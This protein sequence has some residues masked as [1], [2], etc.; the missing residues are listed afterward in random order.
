MELLDVIGFQSG[1]H[2]FDFFFLIRSRKR[3][4]RIL[5]SILKPDFYSSYDEP[6]KADTH[7]ILSFIAADL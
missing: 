7:L 4:W 6:V 5:N 2:L 1:Q 3:G